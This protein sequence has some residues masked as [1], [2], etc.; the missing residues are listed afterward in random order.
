M[1][2]TRQK[3]MSR[4]SRSERFVQATASAVE[5]STLRDPNEFLR[6]RRTG[7]GIHS[8]STSKNRI[9]YHRDNAT[10]ACGCS[11]KRLPGL[12][13]VRGLRRAPVRIT[14][15]DKHNYHLFR[16][17]TYQVATGLL[18]GEVA[19]PLRSI[20]KQQSNVDVSME[21]VTGID[22][23][24][25]LVHLQRRDLHYDF[26][27]LATGIQYNFFGHDEWKAVAPG[28]DSI[29]DAVRIRGKILSAF[30]AA[31]SMAA[32]D[33]ASSDA[34]QDLLTFIVVGAGA[35]GVEIAGTIA[36][37]ARVA[38]P[39]DF[40]HINPHS[41]RILLFEA[42]PRILGTYPGSLSKKAHRHLE[43]L[44]V[45][46][47]TD[48]QVQQ[49]DLD[50]IKVNDKR[51]RSHT[52]LW[53]AGVLASM[54]GVAQAAIQEGKYVADLIRRRVVHRPPPAPFWYWDKGNLAVVGRT[55][56]LAD[57][58]FLRFSRFGAWLLWAGVHIYFLIGFANRLLVSLRW[59]M[60]FLT[61]RR[62]VRIFP[63]QPPAVEALNVP[64]EEPVPQNPT[65]AA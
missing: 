1:G 61:N 44:G 27:I 23:Q 37:L 64:N 36:E 26:L 12:Y 30:E 65:K 18:S 34:I 49:V 47:Y 57:L 25:K 45:T 48:S 40:R 52:V 14:L 33:D 21:E 16:P 54:P 7:N 58:H 3:W 55:F 46:I 9:V 63:Q 62:A 11:G 2:Q 50:G 29:D 6:S 10:I 20:F 59:A 32:T 22:T 39:R 24:R 38:L 43:Q 19:A 42:T 28:L 60:S 15:V 56:A 51:I 41:A 13:A 35:A 8:K 53:C 4:W 31:E 5:G 17:M